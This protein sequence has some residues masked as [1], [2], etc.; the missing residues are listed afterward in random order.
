MKISVTFLFT[1]LLIDINR[2]NSSEWDYRKHGPDVWRESYPSCA[3]EKQ[4]PINIRT[5]CTA[6]KVF[7]QFNFTSTHYQQIPFQLINNGHTITAV[8]NS[9]VPIFVSG[10]G[11][12]GQYSF[13]GFHLHWGP[14]HNSGSEHQV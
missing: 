11:L 3:G 10:G 14:N 12:P 8:P 7:D 2:I 4:S 13:Q 9:S 1:L 5:K 6:Y